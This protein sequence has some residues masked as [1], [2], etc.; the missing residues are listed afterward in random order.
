MDHNHPLLKLLST[1]YFISPGN[2]VTVEAREFQDIFALHYHDFSELVIVSAGSGVHIW[3]DIPYPITCGDVFYINA[4]DRHGYQSVNNLKLDNILYRRDSLTMLSAIAPFIPAVD[5][6]ESQRY[7]QVNTACLSQLRC[8]IDE[9]SIEGQKPDRLSVSLS[10]ALFLQLII[11]LYRYRRQPDT[12]SPALEHQLDM[13]LNALHSSISH[14]FHLEQFCQEKQI[15]PRS[16]RRLFKQ[17]TGMTINGYLQQLRLCR[18]MALL[19]N[20]IHS[21]S[22]IAAEC[23]YEDSNYFASVFRKEVGMTPSE[24]RGQFNGLKS[25]ARTVSYAR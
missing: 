14:S 18:A 4:A 9:L 1:D 15:S 3:N 17:R 20:P 24:Y 13:V 22:Q 21:I 25:P 10:E 12:P 23:G 19:R 16:L 6:P 8:L 11:V 7:W 2:T 5:A